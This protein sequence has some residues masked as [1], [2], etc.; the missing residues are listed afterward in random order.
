[1]TKEKKL[2]TVNIKGKEYV[3]VHERIK[4][5]RE[6]YKNAQ[7]LTDIISNDNG[8]CVIKATLLIDDKIVSTGHAYEK[9][10]STFINKTSYIENCET[11]AVGRC[12]GNFGIG[13]NSSVA[14]ADEVV[15]AINQT[16]QKPEY[17]Q[18]KKR[19]IV[20]DTYSKQ[21]DNAKDLKEL[22]NIWESFTKDE[23]EKYVN[24]KNLIKDTLIRLQN[25]K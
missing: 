9:E 11:S 20:S 16:Q 22:Q 7:L 17:N 12:L 5:L 15:N 1:M 24:Q 21:L 6:N 4:F 25:K 2:K 14:S 23:K 8:V 18:V 3:E 19:Q 13:I 10:A